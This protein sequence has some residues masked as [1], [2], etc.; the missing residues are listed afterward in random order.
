MVTIPQKMDFTFFVTVEGLIMFS[1]RG[2]VVKSRSKGKTKTFQF[3]VPMMKAIVNPVIFVPLILVLLN[4]R[5]EYSRTRGI[6]A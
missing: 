3:R 1:N 5:K 4:A 6:E 2:T